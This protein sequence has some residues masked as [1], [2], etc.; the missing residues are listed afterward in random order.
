MKIKLSNLYKGVNK[1][2]K[3]VVKNKCNNCFSR[4]YTTCD[5]CNGM[6]RI[7]IK[8]MIGP[9]MIQQL[10]MNVISVMEQEK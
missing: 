3:V 10:N 8:R 9:G 4:R 6:G 5:K 1:R 2:V 7:L